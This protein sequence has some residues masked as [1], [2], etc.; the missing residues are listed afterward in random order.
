MDQEKVADKLSARSVKWHFNPPDAS[1]FGGT[2]EALVI[3]RTMKVMLK[4]VLTVDEVFLKVIAEA[5][6]IL[7]SRPLVY[8]WSTS[9]PT[10][11]NA[12]TPNH[13]LHGYASVNVS[14]GEFTCR[15]RHSQFLADQF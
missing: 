6:S 10:D 15:W 12:L 3:K 1:W 14:P 13:F 11:V 8:G 7:N 5:E 4:N 2:W 9:F